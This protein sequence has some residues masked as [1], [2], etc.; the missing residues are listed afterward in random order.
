MSAAPEV[1]RTAASA[2]PVERRRPRKQLGELLVEK[3]LVNKDQLRV[4]LTEQKNRNE[5]LGAIL[6]RLGLI[7]EALLRDVLAEMLRVESIDLSK[8]VPDGEAI[9][10]LPE[11]LARHYSL[12]PITFNAASKQLTVAMADTF[13]VVALDQATALL[14]GEI[15]VTPLLAS[16]A[17]IQEAI[18]LYYEQ[19]YTLEGII[20]ELDAPEATLTELDD[21][22]NADV[23]QPMVRLVDALLSDAVKMRASDIHLEPEEGFLR[24]RYRIDGVLRQM[25]TLHLKFWPAMVVRLKVMSNMNI[26]E[27]R[28]P[29]DGHISLIIAGRPIDFRASAQPTIHGEN[30]V[31]RVLDRQSGIVPLDDLGLSEENLMLLK[32]LMARPEGV[33]LVTGPTGSG[34]TTTL[35][36]MLNYRNEESVN[37]M[38]LEDPVEYPFPMIRQTSLADAIKLDFADGIRSLMRQDPD[39]ILVGEIRDEET[40]EMAF[41]AAM[42]GHQVYSTL[43]TNSAL[44]AVPRLLDIGLR[45]GILAGNIIGIVAQRLVRRL[46]SHCKEEYAPSELELKLMSLGDEEVRVFRAVGCDKCQQQGYMGRLAILEILRFNREMDEAIAEGRSLGEL[47]T[48]ALESNFIPL[49]RDGVRRILAGD[50]SLDEVAR[51]IDL[52]EYV[53]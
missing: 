51:V 11:E 35:Y 36:S 48:V 13:D 19:Q 29:Q 9:S 52:T 26:A 4:A 14:G 6:V 2:Q 45:P 10:M 5:R 37:I 38:T 49:A 20:Q 53:S 21:A 27:T 42:T 3:G 46:C 50:T 15:S 34:K 44:G 22:A 39:I 32:M 41:R 25:W 12:L 23:S 47:R 28:A 8:V 30:Y 18:D 40:A 7:S 24:V 17:E 1:G 16:D 33:I 43:H 31:L